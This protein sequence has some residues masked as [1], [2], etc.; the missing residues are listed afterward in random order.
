MFLLLVLHSVYMYIC[1]CVYSGIYYT[2]TSV[3]GAGVRAPT[4]TAKNLVSIIFCEAVAIYG[5]II[6]LLIST[7]V[8]V[9]LSLT[10]NTSTI[11]CI[12]YRTEEEHEMKLFNSRFNTT[13]KIVFFSESNW[14]LEWNGSYD[15]V[16]LTST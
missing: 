10:F 2:G 9:S 12:Q 4:I 3:M 14:S 1:M 7:K 5:L 11:V 16:G 13:G 15:V 8:S 6:A